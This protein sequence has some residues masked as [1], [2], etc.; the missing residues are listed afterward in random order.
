MTSNLT[1]TLPKFPSFQTPDSHFELPL[2]PSQ[3]IAPHT[4]GPSPKARTLRHWSHKLTIAA[5]AVTSA[6]FLCIA[7]RIEALQDISPLSGQAT[8]LPADRATANAL[9][10]VG[11]TLED[12]KEFQ[13]N[14]RTRFVDR[15]PVEAAS[16]T[17]VSIP[18]A[19]ATGSRCHDGDWR[20]L[21]CCFDPW[22]PQPAMRGAIHKPGVLSGSWDG[23]VMV[24]ARPP[25][26]SPPELIFIRRRPYPAAAHP[27]IL[28]DD[29]GP[30]VPP[31]VR[32]PH[33][34]PHLA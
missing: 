19:R 10:L 26:R 13:Y 24:C 22:D 20:R 15:C 25:R 4:S 34:R 14:V 3:T 30:C 7:I 1:P 28:V 33:A 8:M 12:V 31:V 5:P 29:T 11:K 23:R 32:R 18:G 17:P 27:A 21:V 16:G 6:A 9:G 2:C